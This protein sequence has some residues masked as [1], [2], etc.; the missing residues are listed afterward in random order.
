MLDGLIERLEL[1][2][3]DVLLRLSSNG[4]IGWR[5]ENAGSLNV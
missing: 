1:G 4:R 5:I 3:G 2:S